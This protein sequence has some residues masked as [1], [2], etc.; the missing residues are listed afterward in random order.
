MLLQELIV[1]G[2]S[3]GVFETIDDGQGLWQSLHL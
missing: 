2:C 3:L 1:I